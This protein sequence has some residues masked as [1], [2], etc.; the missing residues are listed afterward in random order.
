[1]PTLCINTAGHL[2]T[3]AIVKNGECLAEENWQS[4]RNETET[5]LEKIALILKNS[6]TKIEEI[7]ALNVVQGIG[8]FTSLRVGITVANTIAY[9][10]KI[11]IYATSV[12]ELWAHRLQIQNAKIAII[13]DAGRNE[14]FYF[15][16]SSSKLQVSSFKVP[17]EKGNTGG[18]YNPKIIP[19]TQLSNLEEKFWIGEISE[20][21]RLLL[22]K[23]CQ[24]LNELK[25]PG[26]AFAEMDLSEKKACEILEPWYGREPNV[27]EPKKSKHEV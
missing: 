3:V 25:S 27:S 6:E 14:C 1:M 9:A 7:E 10:Q 18:F 15:S 21:Q 8:G 2:N 13:V 16:A 26:A 17:L 23:N 22:S 19:N 24:E 20:K 12:F 5:I 11:P 4:Q